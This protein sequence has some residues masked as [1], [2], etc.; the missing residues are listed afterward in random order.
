MGSGSRAVVVA[1]LPP[2]LLVG[3]VAG[4]DPGAAE[5]ELDGKGLTGNGVDDVPPLP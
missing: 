4:R 1:I 3:M 5:K 2:V